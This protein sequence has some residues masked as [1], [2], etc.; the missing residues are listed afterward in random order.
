M[1]VRWRYQCVCVCVCARKNMQGER[2]R[3]APVWTRRA[4]SLMP[5]L[6]CCRLT[7]W[8][9]AP[10]SELCTAGNSQQKQ[11]ELTTISLAGPACHN[12]SGAHIALSWFGCRL[13]RNSEPRL[14]FFNENCQRLQSEKAHCMFKAVYRQDSCSAFTWQ[15]SKACF[16]PNFGLTSTKLHFY[17]TGPFCHQEKTKNPAK[18]CM[19]CCFK[20]AQ[21]IS[22]SLDY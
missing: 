19:D 14:P 1:C 6:C 11:L 22:H 5:A 13:A 18:S 7:S 20:A 21:C 4:C 17:H 9:E 2:E 12:P 15:E 3:C 10:D 8:K 16:I